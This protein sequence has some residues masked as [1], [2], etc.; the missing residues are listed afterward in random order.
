MPI[1]MAMLA[2]IMRKE[3]ATEEALFKTKLNKALSWTIPCAF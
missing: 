1:R 2:L 3:R